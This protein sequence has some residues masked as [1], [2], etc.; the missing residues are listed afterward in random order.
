LKKESSTKSQ[1]V[2]LSQRHCQR[3]DRRGE[4]EEMP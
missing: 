3:K 4:K 2:F 1:Q